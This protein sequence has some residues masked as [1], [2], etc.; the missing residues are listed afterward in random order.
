MRE[1]SI[2]D[3]QVSVEDVG[4][5]VFAKRTMADEF[6]IRA[7]YVRLTEGIPAQGE[8]D[9]LAL[10]AE[11]MS[12]LRVLTV[13]APDGWSLDT[14]DPFDPDSYAKLLKVWGALRDKEV[15]F[16]PARAGG[17]AEG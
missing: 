1:P 9:I 14:L 7:E 11:A 8:D 13:R 6:K 4:A 2:N 5:F 12:V 10:A 17:E 15:T 16:R 3:F